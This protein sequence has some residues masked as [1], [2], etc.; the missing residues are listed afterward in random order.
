MRSQQNNQRLRAWSGRIPPIG[1]TGEMRGISIV[2]I[3]DGRVVASGK[4]LGDALGHRLPHQRHRPGGGIA[5]SCIIM[6]SPSELTQCSA[7][8]S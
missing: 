3:A 6:P 5:P 1:G 4:A 8:L 7:I 2:R